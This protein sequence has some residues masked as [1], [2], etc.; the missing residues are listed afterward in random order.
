MSVTAA[1][2]PAA[3]RAA[4]RQRLRALLLPIY[5]PSRSRLALPV[6]RAVLMR[7]AVFEVWFRLRAWW[8]LAT[9]GGLRGAA[10]PAASDDTFLGRVW[11]YNRSQMWEFYRIRTEKFMAVLRCV[12][13]LP[14]EPRMLVIGPRNEAEILLLSLYGFPLKHITAIDLFSYSPKIQCM[15]MHDIRFPDNSFDIVYSAWTLKY[16]YDL[17]RACRE[18]LRVVRPGGVVV[19]GFSHT[20]A[21]TGEVGAPLAG[22]LAE[23]LEQF[24]PHVDWV[25]WQER[26]PVPGADAEEVSVIF[27]VKK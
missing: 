25:Y 27:R 16:S 9:G 20:T 5:K 22:G 17:P 2:P 6:W 1:A 4:W 23:L 26:T 14:P 12:D 13:A 3:P 7:P 8:L 10:G 15:D 24:A 19:T 18:L 21:I 11:S